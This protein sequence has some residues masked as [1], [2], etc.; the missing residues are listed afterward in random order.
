MALHHAA[1]NGNLAIAIL[2]LQA[3]AN[4]EKRDDDGVT[5][6][7]HAVMCGHT[8]IADLLPGKIN[9]VEARAQWE[10]RGGKAGHDVSG[11]TAASGSAPLLC[12]SPRSAART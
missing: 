12:S 7:D 10:A 6:L 5:A 4:I 8:I 9:Q 11:D 1:R 2:L 3:S